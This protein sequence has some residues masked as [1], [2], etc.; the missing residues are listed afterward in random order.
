M[1]GGLLSCRAARHI[2]PA[3]TVSPSDAPP[4][5]DIAAFLRLWARA[6][7]VVAALA[8]VLIL[9]IDRPL[10][11]WIKHAIP[12]SWERAFSDISRL[13]DATPHIAAAA[14]ALALCLWMARRRPMDGAIWRRRM[15]FAGFALAAMCVNGALVNTLKFVFGRQRPRDLFADGAYG[16]APFD[17]QFSM[18]SFPSGHSQAIWTAATVL[19]LLSPRWRVP[20]FALAT[21]VSAGR[22]LSTK[23][24]VSDVLVGSFLGLVMT[25]VIWR[26]W[27][28]RGWALPAGSSHAGDGRASS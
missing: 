12:P 15:G 2:S 11:L 10:A 22:A 16:F 19:S 7:A 24:Y 23:H 5:Q 14:L 6:G 21:L 18:N 3:M 13:G 1:Q 17:I 28:A 4:A 26:Y 9:A 27:L 25:L 8:V 20:L